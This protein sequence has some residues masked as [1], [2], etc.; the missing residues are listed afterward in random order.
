[1]E[2]I[3]NTIEVAVKGLFNIDV[4][5]SLTRPEPKFGDYA[6]NVAMQLAKQLKQNPRDIAAK[7]VVELK[8]NKSFSAVEV[9]G[10]GFINFRL[11]DTNLLNDL[12]YILTHSDSYGLSQAYANK[13]V[14]TEFSDPNAFKVLHVGHLY[15]SIVGDAVSNLVEFAG[16]QVHRVN[17]GGDVG[18]HVAKCMW[19]IINRLGGEKPAKLPTD[20]S[21]RD[22][23]QW[24]ADSYVEGN[25]AYENETTRPEIVEIN[26]R[27]YAIYETDDKTS[28]FAKIYWDCRSWS[29]DY[30]DDFYE[31]IGVKFEKYYPESTTAPLGLETVLEQTKQGVYEKSDGAIVFN[32]E[33]YG[34]HTRVFI[35]S[36]GLPTYEAKDVGLIQL[37]WQDYH[38]DKSLIITGNDIIDYMKVVVKSIEQFAPQPA[39]RTQHITHGMLKLAG[40]VKM[41]S[42]LGN[43]LK[44]EDVL[45]TVE[46]FQKES[47]GKTDQDTVLGAV[48][49]ALLKNRLGPDVIFEPETSVNAQGNSGPYLQ[50]SLARAKSILRKLPNDHAGELLTNQDLDESERA[51]LTKILEFPDVVQ[52]ATQ[53]L[54]PHLICNYLYELAQSFNRFYEKS[55]VQADPREALRARLV[56]AY[57]IV[58]ER[59]LTILGIPTPE[60]M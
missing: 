60:K 53:D 54:T 10:A 36:N 9:A 38:F 48:R 21:I 8:K 11:S 23:M 45:D 17:F 43:F 28:D 44:A 14:V 32:G 40:A 25:K 42:R 35:N 7:L 46:A 57:S 29:Y 41:A 1:M 52:A 18:L 30:F 59:G 19:G 13:V 56:Y 50:Y 20:L 26:K 47:Q 33:P 6:T 58:L 49:Y 2:N 31:R 12:N 55:K 5:V 24:V 39:Q 15:T 34:L 37:K 3:S 4:E 27:I 51:I 16:G 22:R